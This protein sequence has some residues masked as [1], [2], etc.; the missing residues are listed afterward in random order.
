LKI[1]YNIGQNLDANYSPDG[2]FI[3]VSDAWGNV[4]LYNVKTGDVV[5]E[6]ST[7]VWTPQATFDPQNNQRILTGDNNG[8]ISVWEV[9]KDTPVLS[10]QAYDEWVLSATF[11]P[12]GSKI[13][14]AGNDGVVRLWD[15]QTGDRLAELNVDGG[16]YQARFSA[17]GSQIV[18]GGG[19][20]N[21]AFIF[22]AN[23]MQQ[24]VE[25]KGH[26]DVILA[27][28]FSHDGNFV[29]TAGYDNTIRKW[30]AKTGNELLVMTGHTGRVFDLD[31][32]PDDSLLVS[33]SADTTVKV[34]DTETGKELYNYLGNN[35]DSNSVAFSPD[36]KSVL[37]ASS[38]ETTKEFTIDYE[39]LLGIAQEYE[40]R[41]LTLEECQRFLY[42]NDCTLT[43]FGGSPPVNATP[44]SPADQPTP[45][46]AA[47]QPTQAT[48]TPAVGQ[49]VQPTVTPT[50]VPTTTAVSSSSSGPFYTEEF[51]N[52]LDSWDGFMV[53]GTENQVNAGVDGGSFYVQL[54]PDSEKVPRF[55]LVNPAFDYSSVQ[56]EITTTNYGNNANGVSLVCNYDGTNWYEF[57]ISNAGLYSINAYDPTATALQGYIQLAGGG[58]GAIKSGQATNVYRA[59][60]NGSEL[61]LYI[62]DTLVKTLVDTKY[63][64][65]GGKIGL[66]V[67]SPQALPVE[68]SFES[69]TVSEP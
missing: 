16:M 8:L 58:S 60:C 3:V 47:E 10:F 68:V 48:S 14:S 42:R 63:N 46:P 40:L 32:S 18:A 19:D 62:N 36:G 9:G 67:S 59:I 12:D 41:P 43:L 26:T 65:T 37:T 4:V 17:D 38:D 5:N 52:N 29:Y 25:L 50:M 56:M 49:S 35:E 13:L 51:D 20:N 69:L 30:D 7:D 11:S 39:T 55:Y 44:S 57:T 34:W 54:T 27:L 15:A 6:W 28:A 23:S 2:Q 66:G 31:V 33:G 53:S 24:L 61:T 22:D 64:L 21:S 1:K 45:T